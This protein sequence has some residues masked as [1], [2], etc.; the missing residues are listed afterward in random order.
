MQ[1]SDLVI[2]ISLFFLLLVWSM[3]G[4][5]MLVGSSCQE[6]RGTEG[7]RGNSPRKGWRHERRHHTALEVLLVHLD[8]DINF[9]GELVMDVS[10]Y[11]QTY[12]LS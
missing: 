3:A 1:N 6:S 2:S 12:L 5:L 7:R 10:A 9:V 4:V 8:T 11:A